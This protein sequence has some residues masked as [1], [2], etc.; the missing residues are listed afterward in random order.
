MITREHIRAARAIVG[1]GVRD[2]A[3]RSG[4][5]ANTVSRF[6]N[7]ADTKAGTLA[8]L[9]AAFAAEGVDFPD[10][11]S[12]AFGRWLVKAGAGVQGGEGRGRA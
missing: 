10:G 5:S 8:R 12:V 7:G 3:A 4:V 6:E 11:T 2:L 1:W 9:E